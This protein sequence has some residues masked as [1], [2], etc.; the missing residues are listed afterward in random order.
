MVRYKKLL[1]LTKPIT[2]SKQKIFSNEN[3]KNTSTSWS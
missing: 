2:I 3:F 1:F